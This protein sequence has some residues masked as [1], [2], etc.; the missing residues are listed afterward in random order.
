MKPGKATY[1]VVRIGDNDFTTFAEA[2]A[3]AL[4]AMFE[5]YDYPKTHV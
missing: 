4:T 5:L 3:N 1:L 2:L